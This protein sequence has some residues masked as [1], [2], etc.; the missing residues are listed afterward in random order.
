M[1]YAPVV[2][3][4]PPAELLDLLSGEAIER[5]ARACPTCHGHR[6]LQ[7]NG[8]RDLRTCPACRGAGERSHA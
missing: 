1:M 2:N 4:N 8:A 3:P 6:R 7:V 5:L